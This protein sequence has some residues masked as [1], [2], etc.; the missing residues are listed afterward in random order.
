[1]Y[2]DQGKKKI[3]NKNS[4]IEFL[5]AEINANGIKGMLSNYFV[6]TNKIL[7]INYYR[8]LTINL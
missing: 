3:S 2:S 6:C 8:Y 5:N 7:V 1:M 4:V